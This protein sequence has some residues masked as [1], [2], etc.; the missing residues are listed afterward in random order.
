MNCLHPLRFKKR[1]AGLERV[2]RRREFPRGL[3]MYFDGLATAYA[4]VMYVLF[5]AASH[6]ACS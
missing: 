3:A 6:Q 2:V 4:A 1:G 5:A